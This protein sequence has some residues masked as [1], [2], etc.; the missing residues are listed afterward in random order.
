MIKIGS[1]FS[2]IG[3]FEKALANLGI[4]HEV[5]FFSEIDKYAIK[6][7]CTIHNQSEEKNAGDITKIDISTLPDIDLLTFGFPCQ[8]FS[9]AGKGL[10][11]ADV[12]GTLFYEAWK[13]LE[14]KQPKY[15]IFENVKG[16]LSND[17]GRTIRTI[18]EK[19]GE[20]NYEIT[21]D[22]LNAKDFGIPQNRERL[23]C[24]GRKLN[25]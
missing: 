7:Y 21:M 12:R 20:L 18:L 10:G 14:Y 11:F 17:K 3:A 6:S 9:L 8:P 22:I 15:F 5:A 13:V 4:E 25:G 19:L 1:L 16:L 23:F 2:G 24:V